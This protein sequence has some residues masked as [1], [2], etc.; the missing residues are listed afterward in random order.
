MALSDDRLEDLTAIF[1][2]DRV[3]REAPEGTLWG[4]STGP[5]VY[6]ESEE[7][8]QRAVRWAAEKKVAIVPRGRGAYAGYGHPVNRDFIILSLERMSGVLEHSAGDLTVTVRAGT[9]LAAL[10]EHLSSRGQ[11]L[12]LDPPRPELTTVGGAVATG[13]TGPKRF[14][15]GTVRDWVIGLR[16]VLADGRVIRTG[17]KV[18]K[19][20]AGYDMNKMFIGSLGTLGIITECTF[21]L[22]PVP[23]VEILIL[24]EADDWDA[25]HRLSRRLLDSPLEPSA[26]EAVNGGAMRLFSEDWSGPCGVMVGFEDE[27]LA[28]EAQWER[29]KVW[30]AEEGLRLR[31][32]LEGGDAAKGWRL[33]GESVPDVLDP[34]DGKTVVVKGITL[35][36]RVPE[37]LQ[38][39]DGIFAEGDLQAVGHGGTGT[40]VV[41]AVIR[42]PEERLEA[43]TAA[44]KR[45][46][47]RFEE[48]GGYLVLEQAP[49]EVKE[50]VPVWG[51]PP[52]GLFLMR[53]LKERFDPDGRLN[54]GRFVGGI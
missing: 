51:R 11:F 18:V 50:K 32:A 2:R 42:A 24:L 22:R 49:L 52:G 35:P 39:M 46:R 9:S 54:P 8:V 45:L 29:L 40:G 28:V 43:L 48:P 47:G 37:V 34:P 6:A 25:V 7:E 19:N 15:Y 23:P 12:P 17:G 30:A 21:K 26:V 38:E 13:M 44:L 27:R 1:G 3:V 33:L 16:V 53:R 20:V 31:F 41:R 4:S 14:K 5:V 36:D 10:R